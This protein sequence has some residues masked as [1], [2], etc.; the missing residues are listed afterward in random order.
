MY[1]NEQIKK[2]VPL[3]NINLVRNNHNKSN[4]IHCTVFKHNCVINNFMLAYITHCLV[5]A[6]TLNTFMIS[7]LKN[8]A[9]LVTYIT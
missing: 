6:M 5:Y 1:E 7:I 3:N 9:Y 2:N 4:Q 8:K